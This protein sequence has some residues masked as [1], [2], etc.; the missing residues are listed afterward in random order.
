MCAGRVQTQQ[1]FEQF[2]YFHGEEVSD[3][4]PDSHFRARTD[5]SAVKTAIHRRLIQKLNLDRLNEVKRE[6]V[7]RE[8][9]ANP[10]S[11]GGRRIDSH[12]SAGTGAAGPG[13]SGRSIRTGPAGT[14]SERPDDLRYSGEY[15]QARV[16]GAERHSGI[17]TD[18]ISR[19]CP[20]DE[21]HRPHRLRDRPARR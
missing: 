3:Y 14:A 17:D 9:D 21:H 15:L 20:P 11:P 7:R 16:C 2:L 1:R 12:E 5:F 19:R 10:G 18:S 13:S 4:A 6:E 8:V